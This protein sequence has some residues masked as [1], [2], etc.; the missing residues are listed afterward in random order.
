MIGWCLSKV[1]V[2]RGDSRDEYQRSRFLPLRTDDYFKDNMPEWFF[3]SSK[4][5]VKL[6]TDENTS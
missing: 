6:V 5:D 1:N 4:Y 3:K 2:L